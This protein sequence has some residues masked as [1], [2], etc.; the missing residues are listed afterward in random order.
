[1]Y[2]TVFHSTKALQTEG[3]DCQRTRS[4]KHNGTERLSSWVLGDIS[5]YKS[6]SLVTGRGP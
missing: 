3:I 6:T 5:V 2:P 1:V 4:S